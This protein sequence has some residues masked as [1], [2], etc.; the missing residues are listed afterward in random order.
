MVINDRF[1][2]SMAEVFPAGAFVVADTLA[3]CR[4]SQWSSRG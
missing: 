4:L 3:G 1:R 2:V